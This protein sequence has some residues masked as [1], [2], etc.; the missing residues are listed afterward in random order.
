M[1]AH[2]NDGVG[3]CQEQQHYH[4]ADN[5]YVDNHEKIQGV[6]HVHEHEIDDSWVANEHVYNHYLVVI[7]VDQGNKEDQAACHND[8][9]VVVAHVDDD[10]EAGCNSG[11]E[12]L[13]QVDFDDSLLMDG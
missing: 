7:E 11:D 6:S 13:V 5:V 10:L 1:V 3:G 8:G 2:N 12:Y 9:E 4:E